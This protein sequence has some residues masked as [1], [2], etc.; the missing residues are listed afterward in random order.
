MS[1][2]LAVHDMGGV[3]FALMCD[4][5]KVNQSLYSQMAIKET[6][7]LGRHPINGVPLFLFYDIVHVIKCVRNNWIT[8]KSKK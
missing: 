5:H 4:N 6:P 8:E 7:W 1:I 3:V 2:I